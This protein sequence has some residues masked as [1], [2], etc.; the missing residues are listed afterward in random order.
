MQGKVYVDLPDLERSGIYDQALKRVSQDVLKRREAKKA[1][2]DVDQK[3]ELQMFDPKGR[4]PNASGGPVD[5]DALVQMYIAEGLSYEE[6]IQAAQSAA[7]LPWDT[8]KK[9][10]GGR[11]DFIFG[12]S[13]GL[14]ALLKRLR[15]TKKRVFPSPP[16]GIEK[17]MSKGDRDY[18]KDL[19]LKQLENLLEAAKIDKKTLAHSA[20]V[21][22]MNDPGLN[23]LMGK[24]DEAG[25]KAKNIDKYTDV[26][27]DI[28]DVEM[29]IKNYTEKKLKRRPNY[30]GGRIGYAGGGQTGLPAVTMGTPQSGIQQPQM[31]A[32]PQP[33]GIPGGTIVA[34]NQMHQA[35]WM[36]SQMQQG[37][38]G[39]RPMMGQ[40]PP[41][42]GM[43][44]PGQPRP[45][46]AEGGRIGFGLGGIDK[47][48]RAFL[49]M[50]AGITGA[51]VAAGTGLLKLGKAA[52]V[53][54]KVTESFTHVP[55]KDIP[56]MP[57]WFKPLVAKVI[58]E[59]D[60]VTKQFAV[61]D[62]EVVHKTKLPGSGTDVIVTQQLDTGDVLVDIGMG[63]HGWAA[64][65][66][67]QPARLEYKAAEDIM[68]GPKDEPF[69]RGERDPLLRIKTEVHEDLVG[70]GLKGDPK[71][72][73]LKPGKTKEEFWVDEAE[74]TGGHP[75]NIK[76]EESAIEKYGDHASDFS[77]VE[78]FAVGK[79]TDKKIIGKKAQQEW[80]PDWDDSLDYASGGLA[81]MLGE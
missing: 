76:F 18:I 11:A 27:K 42:G 30:L 20:K 37:I 74:F 5:H 16:Q 51:G 34:Q 43:P 60:D 59:G 14:R 70:S 56:G 78:K 72:L 50:L 4:K 63:K 44:Q 21:K 65:R 9:A 71:S 67:G 17:F 64:G 49:K 66:Y 8:L 77:E 25:L 48:R 79:N 57:V 29:M 46:A 61:K 1:L 38:G 10:E 55:I 23:F 22:K 73:R 28:M 31:P 19:K 35:P 15:G 41:M 62:L 69:K 33:A 3:I 2:K 6:A 52:K 24:L 75:E 26:D 7:N 32:G 45:M 47:A 12:G 54:P 53:V 36:G 80:Q 81:R 13:A 58:K 40:R 68:T 39:Q